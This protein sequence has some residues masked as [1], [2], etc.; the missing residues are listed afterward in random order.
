MQDPGCILYPALSI[1]YPASCMISPSRKLCYRILQQIYTKGV[2]SDDALNSSEME[3]LGI[4][5]RHL[6]TEIV[7]G[8]LRWQGLLDYVLAKSTSRSWREV[9]QGAK[10]LLRMSLYQMW[11][12]DRIPHHALVND[13]VEL[14]K[15]KLG[16][17]SD[18]FLNGVLRNLTRTTPWKKDEFLEN[19]PRWIQASLPQWLWE[20]WIARY[21]EHDTREYALALNMPPQTALRL[22]ENSGQIES[23]PFDVVPSGIVPDAYLQT[24]SSHKNRSLKKNHARY[25]FQDE[26]SQLIP[27]LLGVSNAGSKIWDACAAPGGKAA[28]LSGLC[29]DAG[30][31]TASDLHM[32]R[33]S[34]LR[35][36]LRNAGVFN[37]DVLI[38]DAAQSAPFRCSFDA[39]LAD[40]P[41]SGL[42]TLRRNPEIKWNFSPAK[43]I[44]LQQMQ[45]TILHS[46]STAV[47]VG[48]RLLYSTCSTEPEE[49]EEVVRDFLYHHPEFRLELPT[50]PPGIDSWADRDQ[51][52]RTF[53]STRLWDG[54]FAALLVRRT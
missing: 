41:C 39:V 27:Y 22:A 9:T 20:R 17:G 40:V 34:H 18:R 44:S 35:A 50:Y 38:A 16:K 25:R 5:D 43:L 45:K 54:F 46:V 21:G 33:I 36:S 29:G 19:A 30:R 52:I 26:A 13:A 48:G 42:G 47:R 12:M 4:R 6:T 24:T 14:A 8:T 51:M 28:I 49:N 10:T 11:R 1:L 23:L 15:R 31:V 7:Y 2:F 37:A 32:G 3:R 53:P